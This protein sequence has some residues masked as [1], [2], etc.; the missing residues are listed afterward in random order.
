MKNFKKH[1]SAIFF[2][3]TWFAQWHVINCLSSFITKTNRQLWCSNLRK[4]NRK[5]LEPDKLMILMMI[6]RPQLKKNKQPNRIVMRMMNLKQSWLIKRGIKRRRNSL[7]RKP[8]PNFLLLILVKSR[9]F[10]H[11]L[12]KKRRKCYLK[13]KK[14]KIALV[15]NKLKKNLQYHKRMKR[16]K[17]WKQKNKKLQLL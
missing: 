2:Q 17:K 7:W 16:R 8:I 3:L 5:K 4:R 14:I 13:R 1:H 6:R 12:R 10:L 9:L 15:K 11:K